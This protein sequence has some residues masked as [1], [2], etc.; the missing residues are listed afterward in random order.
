MKLG[1]SIKDEFLPLILFLY[2]NNKHNI[3]FSKCPN[4]QQD[5][6]YSEK[7]EHERTA[8]THEEMFEELATGKKSI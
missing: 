3:F 5:P 8:V 7:I 6:K 2:L 1:P 4:T